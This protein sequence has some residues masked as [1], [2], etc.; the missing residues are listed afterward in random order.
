MATRE[1]DPV[2]PDQPVQPVQPATAPARPVLEHALLPVRPGEEEAFEAAMGEATAYL[3]RQPGC[4]GMTVTRSVE[5]PST[6]LLLVV[7]DSLAAH[8]EGFRGSADYRQWRALLHH[9]Y[10]PFPAV[11]HFV[12]VAGLGALPDLSAG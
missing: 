11:T 5:E 10:E 1:T 12:P 2:Q 8:E 6:Y 7:W 4:R 9:F 3:T